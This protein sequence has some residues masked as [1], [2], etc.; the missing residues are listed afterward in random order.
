MIDYKIILE[1]TKKLLTSLEC[2]GYMYGKLEVDF[3]RRTGRIKIQVHQFE[4][5]G[6]ESI[7]RTTTIVN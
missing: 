5:S 3:D 4:K 2:Q 7:R 1:S 6:T